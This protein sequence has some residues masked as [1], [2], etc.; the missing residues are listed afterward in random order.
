MGEP[1]R[2]RSGL[3]A[4]LTYVLLGSYLFLPISISVTE[5][6]VLLASVLWLV[7]VVTGNHRGLGRSPF[8]VPIL[9]F[10]LVAVVLAVVAMVATYVPALRATHIDPVMA[11][12]GE[13]H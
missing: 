3:F 10:T 6:L 11:L 8:L 12:Q 2:E 1:E 13:G 5:P 4:V 7:V 9:A